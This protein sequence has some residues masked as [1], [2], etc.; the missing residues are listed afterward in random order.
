MIATRVRFEFALV[1][2]FAASLP[3]ESSVAAVAREEVVFGRTG[4]VQARIFC[5][6]TI[7]E[8]AKLAGE[9]FRAD[10]IEFV[11]VFAT[12]INNYFKIRSCAIC[13]L[14]VELL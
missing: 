8:I 3:A 1:Y 10:A 5:Y 4:T 12:K 6:A 11:L 7:F 14:D 2:I 9:T 13:L